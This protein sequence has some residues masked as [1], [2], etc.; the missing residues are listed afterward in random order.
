MI[1]P[2]RTHVA[3]LAGVR[4]ADATRVLANAATWETLAVRFSV[5]PPARELGSAAARSSGPRWAASLSTAPRSKPAAAASERR[6]PASIPRAAAAARA[7]RHRRAPAGPL[8]GPVPAAAAAPDEAAR[9]APA[10]ASALAADAVRSSPVRTPRRGIHRMRL[11]R[12]AA[13]A[14]AI[15]ELTRHAPPLRTIHGRWP[16][17]RGIAEHDMDGVGHAGQ[18][19]VTGDGPFRRRMQAAVAVDIVLRLRAARNGPR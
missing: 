5:R 7:G 13:A 1:C 4:A 14:S 9:H 3:A 2:P 16:V 12:A 11:A 10:Q 6:L 17:R 19:A 18:P 15:R 8:D